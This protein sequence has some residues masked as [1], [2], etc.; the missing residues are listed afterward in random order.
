M[1]DAAEVPGVF[2]EVL[3]FLLVKFLF[4]RF[5]SNLLGCSS[6]VSSQ[7][8]VSSFSSVTLVSSISSEISV[9]VR[10]GVLLVTMKAKD[11]LTLWIAAVL[12]IL[13][14]LSHRWQKKLRRKV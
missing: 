3:Y 8:I 1:S 4:F 7:I 14:L 11:V 13:A 12:F 9:E 2:M 10:M 5:L 6:C